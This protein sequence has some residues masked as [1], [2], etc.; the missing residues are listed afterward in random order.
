M[1][2][3]FTDPATP[4][5]HELAKLAG[6]TLPASL[7]QAVAAARLRVALAQPLN[8]SRRP[9][10]IDSREE[11]LTSLARDLR[12]RV[13]PYES[14][15]EFDAWLQ[16]VFAVRRFRS[17]RALKLDA[18]DVVRRLA[19]PEAYEEVSSIGVDGTVFLKGRSR[20]WP[21]QLE[22][23]A[24]SGDATPHAAAV[25]QRAANRAALRA[26][27]AEWSM[28]KHAEL[29]PF[30]CEDEPDA[31]DIDELRVIV[32]AAADERPIQELLQ[33][34]PALLCALLR[35]PERFCLPQVRVGT[36]YVADFFIADVD[37][38]G[39]RWVLVEL[40]SPASDVAL[41]RGN[42]FEQRARRGVAQI[43]EW[44]EWLQDNLDTARR[45]KRQNGLGLVDIRPDVP[46]L[47]IVGR[48]HRLLDPARVL[49]QRLQE[50][51]Q[52]SM[53]TYDWLIEHVERASRFNGPSGLNQYLLQ[54]GDALTAI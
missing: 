29:E 14:R 44:R 48:R 32:E 2:R 46:G 38:T 53:H 6:L 42:Q 8:V 17:L 19:E 40:E 10:P 28:V 54:R 7:P 47:V 4:L 18:G 24:R 50:S 27:A 52:I 37:S 11:Y 35:G 21:D 45:P 13:L 25:R 39:V 15:E 51:Q 49:R 12:V 9:E 30:L 34:R 5:Q 1:L 41:T 36:K 3:E 16:H 23:V 43:E 33:A 26:P 31:G 20:A 22:V